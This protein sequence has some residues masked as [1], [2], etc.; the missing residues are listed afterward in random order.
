M[1]LDWI[2]NPL[3]LGGLCTISVGGSMVLWVT[4]KKE[5]QQVRSNSLR[6]TDQLRQL[7]TDLGTLRETQTARPIGAHPVYSA[8]PVADA[9][10]RR[11]EPLKGLSRTELAQAI[12]AASRAP[13]N[14]SDLMA[15]LERLRTTAKPA[16]ENSP[17]VP[18]HS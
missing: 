10:F 1:N 15:K 5:I 14:E 12:A 17:L 11:V 6:S 18:N 7:E 4:L 16:T 9:L 3:T 8:D 2:L 13:K